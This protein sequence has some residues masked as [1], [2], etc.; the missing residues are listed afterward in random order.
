LKE[1]HEKKIRVG[2]ND[3]ITAKQSGNID[4]HFGNAGE[5]LMNVLYSPGITKNLMSVSE[6]TS[7]GF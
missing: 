6:L 3:I 2:N 4:I 1:I 7:A 5:T